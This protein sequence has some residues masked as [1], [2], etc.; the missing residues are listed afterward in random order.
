MPRDPGLGEKKASLQA[1]H[2]KAGIASLC[3]LILNVL[4]LLYS[5]LGVSADILSNLSP[6]K[7]QELLGNGP[8]IPAGTIFRPLRGYCP[9]PS[10]SGS[11]CGAADLQNLFSSGNSTYLEEQIYEPC[12][13]DCGIKMINSDKTV[14]VSC[15]SACAVKNFSSS[16]A[17]CMGERA[18]CVAQNCLSKCIGAATSLACLTCAKVTT[19][20]A[21]FLKLNVR[22]N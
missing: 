4:L 13:A 17:D 7:Y 3:L 11:G 2:P 10:G 12:G 20:R 22:P 6:S 1:S 19:L 21:C 5:H 16:C 14:G 15:F 8:D 18:V 9:S